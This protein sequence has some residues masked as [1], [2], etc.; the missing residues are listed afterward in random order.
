MAQ[1]NHRAAG[2]TS[3]DPAH[4][5]AHPASRSAGPHRRWAA[6]ASIRQRSRYGAPW[7]RHLRGDVRV[8]GLERGEYLLVRIAT[9]LGEDP[10]IVA[11]EAAERPRPPDPRSQRSE[12]AGRKDEDGERRPEQHPV[13]PLLPVD[14]GA[15]AR[16]CFGEADTPFENTAYQPAARPAGPHR[17]ADALAGKGQ[18]LAARVANDEN[19]VNDRRVQVDAEESAVPGA[20]GDVQPAQEAVERRTETAAA[21]IAQQ[22]YARRRP[23]GEHPRVTVAHDLRP[24]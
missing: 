21:G 15:V 2:R 24:E 22:A 14:E 12:G 16:G 7:R 19:S 1:P 11:H 13:P 10:P 6:S 8:F 4:H 9:R 20:G 5:L 17:G 18:A 3:Q 23:G